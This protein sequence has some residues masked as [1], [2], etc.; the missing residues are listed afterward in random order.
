MTHPDHEDVVLIVEDDSETAEALASLLRVQGVESI[1]VDNGQQAMDTLRTGMRPCLILLDIMM[2]V[3]GGWELHDAVLADPDLSTIP[4]VVLTADTT[5]VAK[6]S[7]LSLP[8]LRKPVD[9]ARLLAEV[10]RHC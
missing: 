8:L 4:I 5:A 3:M 6:A 2:P 1:V 10:R 7:M 9:A